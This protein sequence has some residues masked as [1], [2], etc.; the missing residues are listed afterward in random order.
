LPGRTRVLL[1]VLTL[2]LY[3]NGGALLHLFDLKT[4][5]PYDWPLMIAAALLLITAAAEP[6]LRRM[7]ETR[8]CLY[9]GKI[10]Y[11]LY[12]FHPLVL[13]AM[14]HLFAGKL[15]LGWLLLLTFAACFVVS[16]IAYRLFEQP[17]LH[18][19]RKAADQIGRG[20]DW[21]RGPLEHEA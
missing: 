2:L 21:L 3:A 13:L 8:A 16:D 15:P 1:G 6:G 18:L 10:S 14:L 20:Y 19:S 4:M 12:L 11:S 17:A 7:L 9:L 5:M